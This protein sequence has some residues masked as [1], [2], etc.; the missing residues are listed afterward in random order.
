VL[1]DPKQA[2]PPYDAIILVAP[3][4]ANDNALMEAIKPLPGAIDVTLM[5]EANLRVSDGASP[6]DVARWLWQQIAGRRAN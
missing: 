3:R 1:G 4:R 5:R 2:I 6:A